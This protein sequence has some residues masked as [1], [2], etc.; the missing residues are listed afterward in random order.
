MKLSEASRPG[1]AMPWLRSASLLLPMTLV[2]TACASSGGAPSGGGESVL[3]YAHDASVTQLD[4]DL[5]SGA[6]SNAALFLTF[7]RLIDIDADSQGELKPGLATEWTFADDGLSLE[8]KLREDV[9]F[10]DGTPFDAEVVKANIERS[11]TVE[12]SN[13]AGDLESIESVEVVDSS[14]VVLRLSQPDTLLPARLALKAGLMINPSA[15][16]DPD[17]GLKGIGG[18]GPYEV[19]SFEPGDQIVFTQY[20]DYWDEEAGDFEKVEFLFMPDEQ[21]R[22]AALRSGQADLAALEQSQV[23]TL[24]S[25]DTDYLSGTTFSFRFIHLN[26]SDPAL[27]DVRVR[28]AINYA[29]DR[30]T[31]MS[32]IYGEDSKASDSI[33]P[34]GDWAYGDY[35]PE[36]LYEYDP[37]KARELL[38]EAGYEDGLSIEMLVFTTPD[39][40]RLAEGIQ[41]Q[42]SEVGVNLELAQTT[43]DQFGE[44]FFVQQSAPANLNYYQPGPSP[45]I[46]LNQLFHPDAFTNPGGNT[47]P[48]V[49]D[50]IEHAN[51]AMDES[52]AEAATSEAIE[53]VR[54]DAETVVIGYPTS[55]IG[56]DGEVVGDV[57]IPQVGPIDLRYLKNLGT[58]NS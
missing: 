16:D 11:Q 24:E 56:Y 31:L 48:D 45:L 34:A 43:P 13:T 21:A 27:E 25:S 54:E 37:E 50:A 46:T 23:D 22:L 58:N 42:L 17:L 47:S 19:E 4:P 28:Q 41:A 29:I 26:R 49:A 6:S 38:A 7:D 33:M 39:F 40:Q 57:E 36:V 44:M 18:T 10:H 32:T 12:G 20:E 1:K 9:T 15:F 30:E 5:A 14:T 51:T 8:L 3:R 52:E 2:L 53:A 55:V 35:S